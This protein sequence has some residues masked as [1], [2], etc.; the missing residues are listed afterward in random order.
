MISWEG[1]TRAVGSGGWCALD[2]IWNGSVRKGSV[3]TGVI[4]KEVSGG[5]SLGSVPAECWKLGC[6]RLNLW[7]VACS[8]RAV[9]LGEATGPVRVRES[10]ALVHQSSA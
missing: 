3:L 4:K 7:S 2:A 8:D 5:L 1:K 9:G 10:L 6:G